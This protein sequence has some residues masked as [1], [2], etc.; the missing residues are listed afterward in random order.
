ME[1]NLYI[2]TTIVSYLTAWPSSH[3]ITA[4]RQTMTRTWWRDHRHRYRLF[5]SEAVLAEV[6]QGDAEAARLRLAAL[7]GLPA[8]ALTPESQALA[9]ALLEPGPIPMKAALDATH[10]GVAAISGADYLLTWNFRH[11]ANASLRKRIDAICRS[12]G[13]EAPVICTPE[14]LLP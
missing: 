3:I 10:I 8:S 12:Q 5:T 4:A 2:E 13:Y 14:E 1:P 6:S 11:L 9:Q 7:D